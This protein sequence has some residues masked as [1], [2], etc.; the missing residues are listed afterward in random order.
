MD[1][2][3]KRRKAHEAFSRALG[4][5]ANIPASDDDGLFKRNIEQG[6]IFICN[7][8]PEDARLLFQVAFEMAVD[9]SEQCFYR[10][11]R[12]PFFPNSGY[13]SV[14]IKRRSG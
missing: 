10:G 14:W 12:E 3:N 6:W 13:F 2:E 9:M 5:G 1:R 7:A 11:S 4:Q 8:N